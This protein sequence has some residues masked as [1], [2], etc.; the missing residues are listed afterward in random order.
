MRSAHATFR[1]REKAPASKAQYNTS[2]RNIDAQ[3]GP[4]SPAPY[5]IAQP[6]MRLKRMYPKPCMYHLRL[7]GVSR[8][9]KEA[10]NLSGR[11]C[12]N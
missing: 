1:P 4:E 6:L 9:E 3:A 2:R 10:P 5:A 7:R 11:T 8:H 12:L